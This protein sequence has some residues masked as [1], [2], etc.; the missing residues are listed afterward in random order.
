MNAAAVAALF[1]RSDSVY[2]TLPNVA[3]FDHERDALTYSGGMPIVAHPPCRAW[4][5]LRWNAKPR[6]GER[7][8][9]VW[10]VIQVRR[11]GGVLEHP[12][13]SYLWKACNLPKPG[14]V[15][16]FGG[17]TMSV[18]QS[19]F[20][21][22]ARKSTLLYIVGCSPSNVPA[23]APNYAPAPCLIQYDKRQPWRKEC[24]KAEREATPPD[25]ASWLV[26]LAC[27]CR[28]H[29]RPSNTRVQKPKMTP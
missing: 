6:P 19:W 1:V 21:H 7:W 9:A 11:H 12:Q 3:A 17:F 29:P 28:P 13:G 27:R 26:E 23:Y 16:A 5:K 14:T 10:S 15:D 24:T 25:F 20:G 4:G 8:L 22:R 18:D 2:K